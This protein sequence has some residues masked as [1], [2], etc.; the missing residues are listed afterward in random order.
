VTRNKQI[1]NTG[2]RE[3]PWGSA[4]RGHDVKN[5]RLRCSSGK[6]WFR[7][8]AALPGSG[9]QASPASELVPS[10][11]QRSVCGPL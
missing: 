4:D 5:E 11:T 6:R 7:G 9:S 2:R 1:R 3:R 10:A 8:P